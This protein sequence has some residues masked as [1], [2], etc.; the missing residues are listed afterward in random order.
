MSTQHAPQ[1]SLVQVVKEGNYLNW[2]LPCAGHSAGTHG[3]NQPSA[4]PKGLLS[5]LGPVGG[6]MGPFEARLRGAPPSR[7]LVL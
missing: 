6:K 7:A 1:S 3:L 4:W 5:S 2:G